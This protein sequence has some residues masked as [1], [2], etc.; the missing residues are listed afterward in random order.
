METP[1]FI[2]RRR[3][4]EELAREFGIDPAQATLNPRK[5]TFD[6]LGQSFTAEGEAWPDGRIEI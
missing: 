2:R 3:R 6:Y 4:L 1:A 5:R